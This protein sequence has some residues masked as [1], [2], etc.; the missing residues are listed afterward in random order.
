M[1]RKKSV[2]SKVKT[3]RKAYRRRQEDCSYAM[4][5]WRILILTIKA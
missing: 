5:S 2:S 4:R 1:V 3:R